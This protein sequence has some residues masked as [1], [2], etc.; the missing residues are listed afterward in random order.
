MQNNSE[1]TPGNTNAKEN[2]A[3]LTQGVIQVLQRSGADPNYI[4]AFAE[5][6]KAVIALT[7]ETVKEADQMTLASKNMLKY[8]NHVGPELAIAAEQYQFL[9][10]DYRDSKKQ[11]QE[12]GGQQAEVMNKVAGLEGRLQAL[13][14]QMSDIIR[15]VA[16]LESMEKQQK[17]SKGS[18]DV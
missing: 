16:N 5:Q 18:K 9:S 1:L 7:E 4:Q 8:A 10:E 14:G 13:E 15:K 11:M 2:A 17:E 6:Q 3:R 12:I